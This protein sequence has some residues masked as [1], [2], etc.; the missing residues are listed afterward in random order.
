M[1]FALSASHFETDGY[2][3]NNDNERNNVN[4]RL[5]YE[6]PKGFKL[7]GGLYLSD[8]DTGMAVYNMPGSP[9]FDASK[10]QASQREMGGPGVTSR[11]KKGVLAW[12]DGSRIEDRNTMLD[13]NLSKEYEKGKATITAMQWYQERTEFFKSAEDPSR[14]VYQRK[15]EAEDGN[16]QMQGDA[17][18]QLGDH[19]V[20]AGGEFRKMG[21][22]DQVIENM[23][24]SEFTGAMNIL[25]YIKEGFKGQNRCLEYWAGYVQDSWKINK[26]VEIQGGLRYEDFTANEIDPDAF[27]FD[28]KDD[29][30][31]LNEENLDPRLTVIYHPW[32]ASALTA[33]INRV[34]RYPT[35]PEYFWWYLNKSSGY[36]NTTL[37]AEESWQYEAEYMQT[38]F[39]RFDA[40]IR[41]YY[42]DVENYL[43]STSVQGVGTV[44]YNIDE[45][46]I[47]GVEAELG[48]RLPYATYLWSNF[49]WQEA[50]K[51]GDPWDEKSEITNQLPYLPERMINAGVDFDG[52]DRLSLKLWMNFVGDREDYN[53]TEVKKMGSYTLLNASASYTIMENKLGK[54]EALLSAENIADA[55]YE[56]ESGYN[57][58]GSSWIG[59]LRASF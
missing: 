30:T 55:D 56:E 19:L 53:G 40:L 23:D 38:F 11:L 51:S 16:W 5:G 2:L 45:V 52:V 24:K 14:T 43:S 25:Y 39:G 47:R 32:E 34:H 6:L 58:P 13:F 10:P 26:K 4:V 17:S 48:L 18:Y 36:F 37:D 15:T 22:G 20:E 49:T 54:W 3:R 29:M 8:S 7:G 12:G 35:S 27:G 57:M 46:T 9:Y 41:Y 59:G 1:S 33:R 28:A 50:E 44:V 31:P 21:W 42:N